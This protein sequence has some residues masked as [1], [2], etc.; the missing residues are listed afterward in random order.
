MRILYIAVLLALPLMT[1]SCATAPKTAMRED[2]LIGKIIRASTGGEVN[3]AD[4]AEDLAAYDVVY[5][6]E[7]HDNPM[8]HAIQERIIR[9]IAASGRSPAIGFEFFSTHHTPLLLSLMDSKHAGHPPEV[10]AMVETQMR[11]KLGWDDQSDRMWGYYWQLLA[12]ARELEL[13][14]AGLDLS[15]SQKRRIT[16]KGIGGLTPLE[17]NLLFSTELSDP[18]YETHMKSIFRSV[19][20]GMDHG[21]MTD[22][23]YDTWQARNDRMALSITELHAAG[24]AE[25]DSD[26]RP[27]PVIVIM[28]NGHTEYGLGV[29]DRVHHLN[30]EI[31]QINLAITEIFR[32][33]ADLEDY[34]PPLDLEG[35]AAVPPA[36]YIWFTQRV[37][38][39]DPCQRFKES[40][41]KMKGA[42]GGQQPTKE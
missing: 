13:T 37:S 35:Y 29:I 33:P 12:V 36:D 25:K 16:R 34:L 38:Y 3:F 7:K 5:L 26:R 10:D 19:H 17:K 15:T 41:K 9:K 8:H 23:L 24:Q 4:L 18:V 11:R 32:Q 28:G 2:P 1:A 14:A 6:S 30:P 39:E 20:C 42:S 21:K 22:R 31:S 40:L 27:G